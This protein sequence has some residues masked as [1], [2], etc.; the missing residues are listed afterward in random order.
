MKKNL[1]F[2]I[3][4]GIA[5]AII[6]VT[7]FSIEGSKSYTLTYD[8]V[9]DVENENPTTY[10]N[11]G[12]IIL[13]D[14]NDTEWYSFNGWFLDV[15]RTEKITHIN[16]DKKENITLY[17]GW[18][19]IDFTV[20]YKVNGEIYYTRQFNAENKVWDNPELPEAENGYKVKWEDFEV[21]SSDFIV[22]AVFSPIIYKINYKGVVG[23][24]H[25]NPLSYTVLGEDIVLQDAVSENYDFLGWYF[26]NR[27]ITTISTNIT[28]D[29]TLEAK[30]SPKT[31]TIE[32]QN[33][34]GADASNFPTYYTIESNDI[35]LPKISVEHYIFNGWI[36][37][38]GNT[39]TTIN[40][41]SYGN[42]V[43]LADLT[44]I[45]Y[46]ITY[47]N[48]K[49]QDL[50]EYPT[51]YTVESTFYIKDLFVEH[52]DFKG[53]YDDNDDRVYAISICSG[54]LNLTAKFTPTIYSI[55]YFNA[56]T[57][58]NITSY[59]IETPEFILND[60]SKK[61]HNFL[62]WY[63]IYG[64]PVYKIDTSKGGNLTL[65]AK[66]EAITYNITYLNT[67]N[68]DISD[69]PTTYTVEKMLELPTLAVKHYKFLGWY[70]QDGYSQKYTSTTEPRDLILSAKWEAIEY[71]IKYEDIR[72]TTIDTSLLVYNYNVESEDIIIPT[73]SK[74]GY[75]FNG[76]YDYDGNKVEKITKGSGGNL[77]LKPK[78]TAIKYNITYLNAEGFD[79][80][81]HPT[82]FTVEK[83]L[84]IRSISRD[85]YDF[86]GWYDQSG[87]LIEYTENCYSD[88]I[89]Y[90][91]WA[92][93]VY[94]IEYFS[95]PSAIMK[96]YPTEYTIESPDFDLP[97]FEQE[98]YKFIAWETKEGKNIPQTIKTGSFGDLKLYPAFELCKYEIKY[99]NV[100]DAS[101]ISLPQYYT[102]ESMVISIPDV[103]SVCNEFLGWYDK[104]GN[105][106]EYIVNK[107]YSEVNLYA[108]WRP[109]NYTITYLSSFEVDTS[110]FVKEYNCESEKIQ[111]LPLEL[112]HY[113]F[114]GWYDENGVRYESIESGSYGNLI[115][116]AKFN[117]IKYNITYITDG[118][119][120]DVNPDYYTVENEF[121][122][123]HAS[124][125]GYT[126]EGWFDEN[127]NDYTKI[128][129][130]S[131]GDLILTSKWS[132]TNYNINYLNVH[133]ADT[134]TLVQSYTILSEDIYL[135][136]ISQKGYE[137]VG[138]VDK[139]GE[140]INAILEGSYG[141]IDVYGTWKSNL[142]TITL[143]TL[144]GEL[145]ENQ[146]SVLYKENYT[147]PILSCEGKTFLGWYTNT[148][149]TG[150]GYTDE[151]GN[152]LEG[153]PVYVDRTLFAR[154]QNINCEINYYIDSENLFESTIVSYG[155]TFNEEVIPVKENAMFAGWY[156]K[157][158]TN[159]YTKD[160]II[161][162]NTEVYA[163]WV[164]SIPIS[165]A[166]EFLAIASK[167]SANYYLTQDISLGG[168]V[169]NPI[170]TFS[171]TLDGMGYAIK[172]FMLNTTSTSGTFALILNNNGTIQNLTLSDFTYNATATNIISMGVLTAINNGNIYN[173]ILKNGIIKMNYRTVSIFG[174]SYF[175]C[176]AAVNNGNILG[177]ESYVDYS[178]NIH[179]E[180]TAAAGSTHD[181]HSYF[182]IGT[183]VGLNSGTVSKCSYFDSQ[184]S[185]YGY[186]YG[187]RERIVHSVIR[188]GG[189]IGE[190]YGR[191]T[192]NYSTSNVNA[193]TQNANTNRSY[194]Y[195]TTGGLVG[196]NVAGD[197]LYCFS[198]GTIHGGFSNDTV[199]GGLVGN[200][201]ANIANCYSSCKVSS[202]LY[203]ARLGGFVGLNAK[204]IQNSYSL[205]SVTSSTQTLIGGFAGVNV[206]TGS[207]QKCFTSTGVNTV[208]GSTSGRFVGSSSGVNFKCYFDLDSP[209]ITSGHYGSHTSEHGNITGVTYKELW[210]E[211]FL[212][213]T[214][215]WDNQGWIF[216]S[217]EAP[218]LEWETAINHSYECVVI[219]PTCLEFGYTVYHCV[220][221]TRFF[222]REIVSS[223]GHEFMEEEII[224]ATCEEL[225]KVLSYCVRCDEWIITQTIE[226][227]GHDFTQ[228]IQRI[229]PTCLENGY[230]VY[231]CADCNTNVEKIVS[232][233][234]HTPVRVPP[235]IQTCE[236]EGH[237]EYIYCETCDTILEESE[238]I[239]P[240]FYN[241]TI[242]L[243]PTCTDHGLCDRICTVCFVEEFD[244]IIPATGHTD[245]NGNYLCDEC[246]KLFGKYNEKAVV[247]INDV[248]DMLAINKNLRGIYR[249]TAN[250]TLPNNWVAIGNQE[251]P[252]AGYF[253][254]NGYT[255]TLGEF[256]S[257][258]YVGIFGYNT[259]IISN[260]T[261]S[262]INIIV[263]SSINGS[264][265]SSL[266][267]VIGSIATYNG[268]YIV[269]CN[270]T[271]NKYLNVYANIESDKF[272]KSNLLLN[273]TYGD[274][275]GI[276]M[277][278][279]S[280]VNCT[281][282]T[283]SVI[284][285]SNTVICNAKWQLS[286]L[287][288]SL[289]PS[290]H[291]NTHLESNL[292]VVF[293]G[294]VGENR[295]LCEN[296]SV[297]GEQNVNANR[298]NV[299]VSNR[300]GY[301]TA[302]TT[303][304]HGVIVGVNSGYIDNCFNSSKQ[305]FNGGE[306]Y[307]K[308]EN[309][310]HFYAEKY[311]YT[312]LIN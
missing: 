50:S 309:S 27:R 187:L 74:V 299:D 131:F 217:T 26:E 120:C 192:E 166:N 195:L 128:A 227:K 81:N 38:N 125:L 216:L 165:T 180:F 237:T 285:V 176:Y 162:A 71:T 148:G 161:K 43:L 104:E 101:I 54:D 156:S 116:N 196:L 98:H 159:K 47:N 242:T 175:G 222:I 56:N 73:P 23:A 243:Y 130:G 208:S 42:K 85:H 193:Y 201:S 206:S 186:T 7:I 75:E 114:D 41:G 25:S 112:E 119:I 36:D 183:F 59:T 99:H 17:A 260:L 67:K 115:L 8:T 147:L 122:L 188:V 129:K 10:K 6:L 244:A 297:D 55:S 235:T 307:Y 155:D 154:W 274:I 77:I 62:G 94:T 295:G 24:T 90:P 298:N 169:L 290:K 138:W 226:P 270:S 79:L 157:D 254:G 300:Y 53:W 228:F 12:N 150:V 2:F 113:D 35:T 218:I 273:V 96:D 205:G 219:E 189:I 108:K 171:G 163:K 135:P 312:I 170:S 185:V 86:L 158:F 225:G 97:I 264:E 167:P 89:L 48:V 215:Y 255:I 272:A 146:V 267:S 213:N 80:S 110:L 202:D 288:G 9:Y 1:K 311:Y 105:K 69:L 139:N 280:V 103:T 57:L 49:G 284:N 293:G 29:I 19:P 310:S 72:Y 179:N 269:D 223:H 259:G 278:N 127:D 118:E 168:A 277:P 126:F 229:E 132:L 232:P 44:P 33:L 282:N 28:S 58:S 238:K 256:N 178:V 177:C 106:I 100:K 302:N 211:E 248:D 233:T 184:V 231:Y 268:G 292:N 30:W 39:V 117:P 141:D 93:K 250:I 111:L 198:S 209:I 239:E 271:G 303:Y 203:A 102:Y 32:Y 145:E 18:S 51:T 289:G 275:V 301:V 261:V 151:N 149:I 40:K 88:L 4:A 153:Y 204:S 14:L 240:H 21:K 70:N 306:K 22:N 34:K 191:C 83:K 11:N 279:G 76:W 123:S 16:T 95:V 305:N 283:K 281:S 144:Y 253:D 220:D 13:T 78:F 124:K 107:S 92:P 160:T 134:S 68:I 37:Q 182:D 63:D 60:D 142:Y 20:T 287:M 258:N 221:C 276:N 247:E 197:I 143:S 31:Y 308:Y 3:I 133:N 249:L 241:Q 245:V 84:V 181:L 65:H 45:E 230:D 136:N 137:F 236:E 265:N 291:K 91:K 64:N 246:G 121:T 252:F 61:F 294:L 251:I 82:N 46:K 200:N 199:V 266:T 15:E 212:V 140:S 152:S 224:E 214:L 5:I 109:I 173:C 263:Q 194:S 52:Y 234:G 87:R 257:V 262:G 296:C 190:N 304:Y 286:A 174:N 66:W 210:S 172:D 207:I 164:S